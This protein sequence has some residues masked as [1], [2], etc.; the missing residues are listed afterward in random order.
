[1]TPEMVVELTRNA[2]WTT[3][4]IGGPFL[5]AALVFGLVISVVQ[6]ATQ[7]NEMTL[8]FVPKALG[9][10]GVLW[11]GGGW[12]LETWLAYTIELIGTIAP[13]GMAP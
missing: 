5:G 11:V 12:F 3:M 2:L 9:V 10:G 4:L 13:M 6:A 8:S 1:M 7:V